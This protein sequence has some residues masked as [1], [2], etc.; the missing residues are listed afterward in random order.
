MNQLNQVS[1]VYDHKQFICDSLIDQIKASQAQVNKVGDY[2][3]LVEVLEDTV[4][5]TVNVSPDASPI[6]M[7]YGITPLGL[8]SALAHINKYVSVSPTAGTSSDKEVDLTADE[9]FQIMVGVLDRGIVDHNEVNE[10]VNNHYAEA[11][12]VTGRSADHE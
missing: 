7:T 11:E 10:R 5:I 2:L 4:V 9:F 1:E 3:A 6:P 12:A 8:A